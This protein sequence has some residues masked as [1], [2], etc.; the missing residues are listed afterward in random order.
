M[1]AMA[2]ELVPRVGVGVLICK[3]NHVLV[4]KRRS[5]VGGGKYALPGGF[6]D[7]GESWEECA[8]RE[9]M[10]ETGLAI[11]NVKFAHVTNTVMRNER[12]PSHSVTIFMRS[13]LTNPNAEPENLEPEKCEGWEWVEWPNVPQPQ[14]QPLQSLIASNYKISE[15]QQQNTAAGGSEVVL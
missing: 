8:A 15:T 13:E 9:V 11:R 10:E 3:G 1:Q 6:L 4:G 12:R 2:A 14:F 5:S 7:F